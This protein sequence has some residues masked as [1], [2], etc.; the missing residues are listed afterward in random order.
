M[1]AQPRILIVDDDEDLCALLRY[2]L[3]RDG[4][5]V[6]EVHDGEAALQEIATHLPSVVV[7]D[8]ILPV[9]SGLEVC[10]AIRNVPR[11]RDIPVVMVTG[12]D[13]EADLVQ[14]FKSGVD[15]YL[16]KPFSIFELSVR[17]RA[18]I[19]RTNGSVLRG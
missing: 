11:T 7:L 1:S 8:W 14:G 15:D 13:R 5:E 3:E 18:I 9:M 2:N 6:V 19:R 12:K 16:I 4:F 10:R 17:I